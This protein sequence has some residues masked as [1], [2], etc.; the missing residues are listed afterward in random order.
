MGIYIS[1]GNNIEN[2]HLILC[3]SWECKYITSNSDCKTNEDIGNIYFKNENEMS[4]CV[5]P[6]S[7]L[8]EY[9]ELSFPNKF[10]KYYLLPG[11]IGKK[12]FENEF[13]DDNVNMLL[14]LDT[15]DGSSLYHIS[16]N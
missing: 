2:E 15:K 12:V 6:D 1:R 16:G 9:L 4:I 3:G 7:S 13:L 14:A 5:T 11:K 8:P 10:I